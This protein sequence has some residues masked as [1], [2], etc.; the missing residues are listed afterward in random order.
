MNEI[1][2]W[3]LTNQSKILALNNHNGCVNTLLPVE[4]LQKVYLMSGSADNKI[5]LYDK[6]FKIIHT[7]ELTGSVLAL[8]Y[9]PFFS[10][11][12]TNSTDSKIK[13][14]TFAHK[15]SNE[16]KQSHKS[17]INTICILENGLIATGS[18][19]KTIKI[20]KKSNQSSIEL[21]TT[22]RG[23]TK[24]VFSLIELK[25]NSLVSSSLDKSIKV[26]NQ[27]NETTF[28]CIATLNHTNYIKSLAT[29]GGSL[30]ISGHSNGNI[31]IRN[32]TSFVLLQTLNHFISQVNSLVFLNNENLA[33]A[34]Y[35]RTIII[36]Q[37]I[38]ETSFKLG[39]TLTQHAFD[40]YSLSVLPNKMFASSSED[41]TIRIWDQNSYECV[42]V[43]KGHTRGVNSLAVLQNEYLISI[44]SDKTI[45]VWNIL[46]SF[47]RIT[48]T[49]TFTE[50]WSL[51]L[52]SNDT[53]ITGDSV[54]SLKLWDMNSL[55]ISFMTE[56]DKNSNETSSIIFY[57]NYLITGHLDG[58][59]KVW[60]MDSFKV[61]HST[62]AH[63]SI[64]TCLANINERDLFASGS[65][66]N[67]I[68]IWDSKFSII[69]TLSGHSG[70]IITLIYL[71]EANSL[72]S[73]SNDMKLNIY[74]TKNMQR[75]KEIKGHNNRSVQDI[76]ILDHETN[77]IA[78]CS[79][80]KTIKIWNNSLSLNPILI[81]T[82][83]DH[84]DYVYSLEYFSKDNLLISSSRDTTIKLWNIPTFTLNKTLLAHEDSVISLAL[85]ENE[86]TLISGSCDNS[87]IIWNLTSF[88]LIKILKEHTGC[89]NALNIFRKN[90]F[91]FS[92][93]SDKK[94]FVWNIEKDFKLIDQL[95]GHEKA[96][97][98]LISFNNILASASLD[99][100]IQIRPFSFIKLLI[101]K[102]KAHLNNVNVICVLENGL[103]ATTSD[104]Q[105]KIWKKI[106]NNSLEF[107]QNLIEHTDWVS[108]LISLKNSSLLSGSLDK[109][110]KVWNQKNETTFE[111]IATLYQER[112]IWSLAISGSNILITGHEDGSIRIR[113]QTSFVLF[114]T[115]KQQDCVRFII[116]LSKGNLASGSYDE[117]I[118]IWQK[119]NE[120]SFK[121]SKTLT[122]HTSKLT[123]LVAL[124]NNIFASSS[125]DKTIRIWDQ[126]SY[127]C[128]YVL[129]D[130]TDWVKSLAVLQ[131]EYLISISSDKTIIVWDILN[132]FS[133]ITITQTSASPELIASFSND[134]FITSAE[135][136]STSGEDGIIQIWSLSSLF[137]E[138]GTQILKEH[139]DSVSDLA[140]LK[141]GFLVSTSLDKT[142]KIWDNS[143]K[144]WS[145]TSN[146]HSI[147][148]VALKVKNNGDLISSSQDGSI[149]FW[150]TDYFI[151]NNTIYIY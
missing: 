82:L 98:S 143:F 86:S 79:G 89:V 127:E 122:E 48:N 9:N 43:L 21:V 101:E 58:L 116:V 142:I 57:Q 40:V 112:K 124:P 28:E 46:N 95:T 129:N 23:H 121:L 141:N 110:I 114:Q 19:D 119:I 100:T 75:V 94:I 53:F 151:L 80:D 126:N 133:R 59:I 8:D 149:H 66:D 63:S 104:N 120:T 73:T 30:L 88:S 146:A 34:S 51:S 45:I 4:I 38:N 139:N 65:V 60:E 123:S 14:L 18:D 37:K 140:V 87:I 2:I 117:I 132:S 76:A 105:I 25:N 92:G 56:L 31:Q 113:N 5:R 29:S 33:S 32:Q 150:N 20:W 52:F 97:T 64:V 12:A 109:S 70:K 16:I 13:I 111:C 85:I 55:E 6:R 118:M 71:K 36:W 145:S 103:I 72:I 39:K 10:M 27:K 136:E 131:N 107:I 78:T 108:A 106:N 99:N 3:N 144:L 44:S 81:A 17:H 84:V 67:Q 102:K 41:K 35:D 50:L 7:L 138:N 49:Q 11:I 91:M 96:I 22:L 24:M 42:Y 128:I 134:S 137:F 62:K 83:S 147:G 15:I 69:Q 54:G 68:K 1:E 90:K 61:Y 148:A 26:W 74:K 47:S 125:E 77:L 135:D 130:H 115:L 93:S